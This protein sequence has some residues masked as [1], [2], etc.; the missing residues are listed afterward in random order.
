M[1]T[2]TY[3]IKDSATMLR[4]N[5]RHMLRYP[6]VSLVVVAIPVILLLLFVYIL[7][8]TLGAGLTGG[9]GP[10]SYVDYVTPGILLVAIAGAAQSTAIAVAMDMH[11]GIITRFKTMGI[12]R[13]SVATGH[14]LGS[15][16]QTLVGL[17]IVLGVAVLMGFRPDATPVEWV[18]TAGV[19]TMITFAI[20]WLSVALGL[21]PNSVEAAS[22]LPMPL[23]LLPFLE[24]VRPHGLDAGGDPLV[25][26]VPAAH[27]VH[28]DGP[29]AAD[30][31]ADRLQ[32]A[33][34]RRLVRG[35]RVLRLPLGDEALRPTVSPR[36]EL[37]R[38]A[39][40]QSPGPSRQS[41]ATTSTGAEIPLRRTSR[42]PKTGNDRA[43][44]VTVSRLARISPPSASDAI[45][46]ASCTPLPRN[47]FPNLD[48]A[49]AWTP[50]LTL[51][52]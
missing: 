8:G 4:R 2:N 52:A 11:E 1:S 29:G 21:A 10:G 43:E 41:I 37:S 28:R 40:P 38:T 13:A 24:R 51:G 12:A 15:T 20:T 50:I 35:D 33:A 31:D 49:V 46:A 44:L 34:R 36:A 16:L 27:T 19:L 45:R 39:S 5:L 42:A 48:A 9:S 17:T 30:G 6:S 25:R 7:G 23:I 32:R 47:A 26:R 18:A 14:V 3:V 22:N